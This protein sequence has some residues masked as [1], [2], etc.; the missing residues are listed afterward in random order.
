M[1][2]ELNFTKE[3][4]LIQELTKYSTPVTFDRGELI[5]KSDQAITQFPM[6]LSGSVKI[7][8]QCSSG[9][10]LLLYYISAHKR[11]SVSLAFFVH[12]PNVD[13][14][15]K[16]VAEEKVECLIV[17]CDKLMSWGTKFSSWREILF[18]D[19]Q[20]HLNKVMG[21]LDQLAFSNIDDR[22]INYLNEKCRQVKSEKLRVTHQEIATD[23][24]TSRETIS[25]LLKKLE[26]RGIIGLSR[27]LIKIL[28]KK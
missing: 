23:L 25:R 18:L 12:T 6:I 13:C 21:V 15:V 22:L 10:E 20:T 4:G 5:M 9:V 3:E 16:A 28:E 19:Y 1:K 27:N 14:V 2:T 17:P 11:P 8:R 24:N 26:D 7:V